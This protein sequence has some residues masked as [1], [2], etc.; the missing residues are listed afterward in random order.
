MD[1]AYSRWKNCIYNYKKYYHHIS[2]PGHKYMTCKL[3]YKMY[4]NFGKINK[5]E[6]TKTYLLVSV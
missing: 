3:L 6:I 2:K 4:K 1:K 5:L